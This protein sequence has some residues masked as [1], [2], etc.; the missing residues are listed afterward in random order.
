MARYLRNFAPGYDLGGTPD[1]CEF[2]FWESLEQPVTHY[3]VQYGIKC[4]RY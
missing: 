2:I 3:E 4:G 1:W